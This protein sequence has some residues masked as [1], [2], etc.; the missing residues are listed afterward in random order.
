MRAYLAAHD[1]R[2]E[3]INEET[4]FERNKA[5]IDA[6]EAVNEND[7]TRKRFEIMC[8]EVFKKFKA[9]LN[10]KAVNQYRHAYDAINIIYKSLQGDVERADI[11]EIIRELHKVIDEVVEVDGDG[12]RGEDK[13][14]DISQID[15]ERLRKEFARSPAK[16]TTVQSLKE[17]IENRLARLL[18]QNPLRTNFQQH[19]EEIVNDYNNEK[20]RVTIEQTFEALLKLVQEL[21]DEEQ[22]AVKEG[23]DEES[24]ALFD[25]LLKPELTKAE[26]DRIKKVATGLHDIL[27]AEISRVQD[28]FAKQATRDDIKVRIQNYL[29]DEIT[30]LPESFDPD[31]IEVK[32]EAVL[33]HVMM[34]AKNENGFRAEAG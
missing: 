28:V 25:L 1:F 24:L 33:A 19:Y 18:I 5:I 27:E 13:L 29:W 30:G 20:D 4:G 21:D 3:D 31:E 2:L 11:S 32:T 34:A 16:N 8:R 7:E 14:Y 26:I 17:V 23:L 10:I 12:G 22:R 9:C 6:K 15:F